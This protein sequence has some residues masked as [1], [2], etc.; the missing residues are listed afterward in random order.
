VQCMCTIPFSIVMVFFV[1]VVTSFHASEGELSS[2]QLA[3]RMHCAVVCDTQCT[4]V[5]AKVSV[6]V[7]GSL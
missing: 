5:L 4:L 7:R 3:A 2:S 1:F 6:E